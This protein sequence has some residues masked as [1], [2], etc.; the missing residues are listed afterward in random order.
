MGI[1]P[2]VLNKTEVRLG[3]KFENAIAWFEYG[4]FDP[5]LTKRFQLP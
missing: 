4:M 1:F 3:G 2:T 5:F